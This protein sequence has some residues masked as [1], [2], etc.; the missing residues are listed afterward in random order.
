M[1]AKDNVKTIASPSHWTT[2]TCLD[3]YYRLSNFSA[4]NRLN[5]NNYTL[6]QCTAQLFTIVEKMHEH[7]FG[8]AWWGWDG[9]NMGMGT[10]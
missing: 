2:A 3:R 10:K 5:P 4:I 1:L 6:L 9:K 7:K 8:L